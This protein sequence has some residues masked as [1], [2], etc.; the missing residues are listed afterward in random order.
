MIFVESYYYIR[1]DR[2]HIIPINRLFCTISLYYSI[3]G[4]ETETYW[5]L[6]RSD[7]LATGLISVIITDRLND[8][9]YELSKIPEVINDLFKEISKIRKEKKRLEKEIQKCI[10]FRNRNSIL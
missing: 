7:E 5:K 10:E 3:Y 9:K 8:L 4:R 6:M 1:W 2:Q